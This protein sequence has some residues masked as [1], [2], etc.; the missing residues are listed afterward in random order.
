MP[1]WV[2]EGLAGKDYIHFTAAGA[3]KI[4]ELFYEALIN[5]YNEYRLEKR[6]EFL[7]D[8]AKNKNE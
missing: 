8:D 7:N 2:N 5:D 1:T 6:I 3:K 4:A